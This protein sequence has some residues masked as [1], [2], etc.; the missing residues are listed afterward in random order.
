M[1]KKL[2]I[3]VHSD[4]WQSVVE[5]INARLEIARRHREVAGADLRTLDLELGKISAFT[6]ILNLP[7]EQAEK[8]AEPIKGSGVYVP[9]H[10]STWNKDD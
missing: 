9:G 3:D 2:L 8:P 10:K 7:R 5:S 1:A 6:K 4:T